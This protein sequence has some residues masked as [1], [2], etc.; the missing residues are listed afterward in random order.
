MTTPPQ[1]QDSASVTALLVSHD[2]V[3]WLPAVLDALAAQPLDDQLGTS[4]GA[5]GVDGEDVVQW[6]GLVSQ[7]VE[8]RRQP[9]GAVVADQYGGHHDA[10]RGRS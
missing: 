9:A 7:T 3:R 8:D 1:T 4:V 2:G 10:V 5:A 6:P